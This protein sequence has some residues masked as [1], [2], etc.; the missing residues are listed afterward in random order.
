M[1]FFV[2]AFRRTP[3]A[4]A[5]G[6]PGHDIPVDMYTW[7]EEPVCQVVYMGVS[8]AMGVGFRWYGWRSIPFKKDGILVSRL[9]R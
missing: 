8:V 4:W 6:Y 2:T 1:V 7:R 3:A 9:W 5:L